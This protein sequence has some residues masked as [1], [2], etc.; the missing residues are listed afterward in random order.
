MASRA[1]SFY[2]KLALKVTLTAALLF[3][4]IS[5]KAQKYEIVDTGG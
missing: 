4:A 2:S 3:T 1:L 5:S